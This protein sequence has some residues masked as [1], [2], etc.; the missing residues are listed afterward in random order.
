MPV[1]IK[2]N[3]GQGQCDIIALPSQYPI[4][5][6]GPPLF[7]NGLFYVQYGATTAYANATAETSV[8]ANTAA[9]TVGFYTQGSA[10]AYPAST[11]LLPAGLLN[12]G[13]IIYGGIRGVVSTTS[14][15]NLTLRWVLDAVAGTVTYVIAT[16]GATAT[17][18]GLSGVT[19][20]CDFEFIV[21]A[22][23]TSGTIESMM[24]TWTGT[25]FFASVAPASVTVDTT[26]AYTLD[27]LATWGTQSSSNTL[28][29]QY[30]YCGVRG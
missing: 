2:T 15:P 20:T 28:T 8:L 26:K 21:T 23:G 5:G 4:N 9:K 19:L 30:A 22:V 13:T 11:L 3:P 14:T 1:T 17:G 10:A 24:N 27:C 29:M 6:D 16:T 18:S 7:N 12:V 25:T